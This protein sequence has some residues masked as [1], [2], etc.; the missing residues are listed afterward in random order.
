VKGQM[1]IFGGGIM[2]VISCRRPSI[3]TLLTCNGLLLTNHQLN[4]YIM[5]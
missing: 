4:H 1:H 2:I 5:Q 3:Y